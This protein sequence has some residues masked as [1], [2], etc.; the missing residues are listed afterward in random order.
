MLLI[1]IKHVYSIQW[2]IK[3]CQ[4]FANIIGIQTLFRRSDYLPKQYWNHG[5][6]IKVLTKTAAAAHVAGRYSRN[7]QLF[8][9]CIHIDSLNNTLCLKS[10]KKNTA[11][12]C[13][14]NQ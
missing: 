13:Q 10:Q 5:Q 8:N 11:A 9:A 3:W 4:H 1:I 14:K 7:I 2:D 12:S 6:R